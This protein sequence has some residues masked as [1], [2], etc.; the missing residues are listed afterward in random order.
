M[1]D[2][3]FNWRIEN[4]EAIYNK[5]IAWWKKHNAFGGELIALKSLPNR[6][7]VV[8]NDKDDLFIVPVYISDSDFCQIGFITSNPNANIKSKYK[9]LDYLYEIISIVMKSQG[10]DII[11]S[12]TKESGLMRALEHSNFKLIEESNF[13]I[14][15]L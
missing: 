6:M 13:Y 2:S 5:L 4:K 8:S 10:F 14:K 7:F 15:T 9:A 11:V 3:K 12:K 1:T